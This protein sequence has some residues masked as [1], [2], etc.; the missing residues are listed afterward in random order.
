MAGLVDPDQLVGAPEIAARLGIR[1]AETVHAWRRRY[2]D[3]PAPVV[4][5]RKVML[6]HWPA[7]ERWARETGRLR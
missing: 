1:H 6:W 4:T 2:R 3:F 7:V 5:L